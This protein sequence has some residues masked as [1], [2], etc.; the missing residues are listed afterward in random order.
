MEDELVIL[1]PTGD[2]DVFLA[3]IA[4]QIQGGSGQDPQSLEL[5]ADEVARTLLQEEYKVI[6][7]LTHIVSL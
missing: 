4:E 5:A 1:G 2:D 3:S 7:P 6:M